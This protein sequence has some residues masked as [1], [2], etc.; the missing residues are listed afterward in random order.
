MPNV[1]ALLERRLRLA[2]EAVAAGA[3]PVLRRSDRADY[4]VN[5]VIALA[6]RTGRNAVELAGAL[7]DAVELEDL[8][9]RVELSGNGFINLWLS[10]RFLAAELTRLIDDERLGL[11]IAP[12]PMVVV[13]DYSA[14]NVAKEMHVG[15]LRSTII[16]D[17]IVRVLRFLGHHVIIENHVGDWGAPSAC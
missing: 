5:G 11:P 7:L 16:G 13:V 17:V 14:P 10:N 3:D 1:P 2:F 6:R 4:Q 8:C 9:E 12:D 15:H